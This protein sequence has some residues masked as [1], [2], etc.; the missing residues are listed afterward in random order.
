MNDMS[1]MF[2]DILFEKFQDC[3]DD[4]LKKGWAK[5]LISSARK[6][7]TTVFEIMFPPMV[8][9][10][11]NFHE[12]FYTI[13]NKIF[14]Y[15]I[16]SHDKSVSIKKSLCLNPFAYCWITQKSLFLKPSIIVSMDIIREKIYFLPKQFTLWLLKE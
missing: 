12:K 8:F 6:E 11:K 2:D 16:V 14:K 10:L 4:N 5:Q 13:L 9:K 15:Q 7:P 1:D 3:T